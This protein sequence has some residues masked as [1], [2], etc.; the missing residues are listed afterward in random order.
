MEWNEFYNNLSALDE[1][2]TI[3]SEYPNLSERKEARKEK[4]KILF[5][6]NKFNRSLKILNELNKEDPENIYK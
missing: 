5:E 3:T 2:E 1:L 4:A 6:M